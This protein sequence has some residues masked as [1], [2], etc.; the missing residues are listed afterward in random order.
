MN[1]LPIA[2]SFNEFKD[3]VNIRFNNILDGFNNFKSFTI[4]GTLS[5][6]SESSIID[7]IYNIFEENDNEC[8]IDFYITKINNNEKDNLMNLIDDEYKSLLKNIINMNHNDIYYKVKNKNILP[9]FIK[10]NTREIF[11]V[12]FYF[13]KNPI[14]IWGNYKLRFPCFFNDNDTFEHYYSIAKSYGILD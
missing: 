6:N 3:N 12:T 13:T 14:T 1:N 2:I 4:D 7:F 5:N 9:F 11:F 8:Y 10:L